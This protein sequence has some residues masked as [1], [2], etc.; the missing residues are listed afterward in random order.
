[1]VTKKWNSTYMYIKQG[2]NVKHNTR[3]TQHIHTRKCY[4]KKFKQ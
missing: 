2:N 4:E 3:I 1:M